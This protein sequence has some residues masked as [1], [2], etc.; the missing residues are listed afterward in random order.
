MISIFDT[1]KREKLCRK[2]FFFNAFKALSFNGISGDY[3]EFGCCGVMTF[4][5][6]F[7]QSRQHDYPVKMWAF[8][9]FQGL[10]AANSP[11][12]AHPEW[13]Q[14]HMAMT[15]D[16]FH[17]KCAKRGVPREVYEVVPG[18]YNQS[19]AQ[20]PRDQI[21]D[22]CLAYVDCDLYSSTKDVLTFLV[23]RLKHGMIIAFDDYFC[24]SAT[25]LAGE[26]LAML[27]TFT[28][29]TD[30]ELAPFM[31]IGWHGFSFVVEDAKLS[32]HI[33]KRNK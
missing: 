20:V 5:H 7:H 17:K 19:L 6:A 29:I 14:N 31:R 23:P 10:P 4:A 30:W 15:L 28:E 32:S 11:K 21:K 12:D 9:S 24:W 22:I 13:N 3:A 33:P 8:D 16:K 26:R 1:K 25:Q 2:E 18:F 27:E